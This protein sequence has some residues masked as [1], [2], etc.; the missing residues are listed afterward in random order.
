[1]ATCTVSGT[2]LDPSGMA[3]VSA[4]VVFNIQNPT[5]DAVTDPVEGSTSTDVTGAWSLTLAQGLSGIFT[6]SV[7][8]NTASRAIP[9]KFN[10]IIPASSTA[11]FSSTVV[12][13]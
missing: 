9:Y 3:V 6:I 4:P 2:V 5:L 11:S 8:L 12:D 1:M 10:S 13:S 7:P